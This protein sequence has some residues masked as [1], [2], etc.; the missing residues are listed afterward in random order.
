MIEVRSEYPKLTDD[1]KQICKEITREIINFK[2]SQSQTLEII[3]LLSMTL[4]ERDDM[5][6][7]LSILD[8]IL[9]RPSEYHFVGSE[10]EAEEA[11]SPILDI[12]NNIIV[13]K[14]SEIQKNIILT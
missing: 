5:L 6:A 7:I 8:N 1:Q 14:V 13:D 10:K 3:K 2:I 4:D 11:K 9:K 12:E